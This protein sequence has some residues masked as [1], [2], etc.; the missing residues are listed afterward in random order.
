MNQSQIRYDNHNINIKCVEEGVVNLEV[1]AYYMQDGM[2]PVKIATITRS[3][4][5]DPDHLKD[6]SALFGYTMGQIL[7]QDCSIDWVDTDL[8]N[9]LRDDF[10]WD[11]FYTKEPLLP[12]APILIAMS[13]QSCRYFIDYNLSD[14]WELSGGY[15]Y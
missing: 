11:S 12:T 10:V 13:H 5:I 4:S 14:A 1:D 7:D 2:R 8:V 9:R 6:R 3:V 15:D